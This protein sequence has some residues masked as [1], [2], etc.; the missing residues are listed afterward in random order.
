M[1]GVLMQ[2]LLGPSLEARI[3]V[4][5]VSFSTLA[6]IGD[7]LGT[8]SREDIRAVSI[9]LY[10]GKYITRLLGLR[11]NCGI[12]LLK[13]EF[14]AVDLVEPTLPALKLMLD[15]PPTSADSVDPSYTK[16]VHGLL[17]S[18]LQNVDE[19][20]GRSGAVVALKTK[21]NLLAAVL[22]LTV[23]PATMRISKAALEQCAYLIS[24]KLGES[25]EVRL[26]WTS[27]RYSDH[28]P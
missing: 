9:A 4:L 23:T 22:I 18:C 10:A 26:A 15:N 5:N 27:L 19:C 2:S 12:D 21:N 20:S 6:N 25:P 24:Q 13:N 17:S 8:A 3:Q 1:A 7:V 16:L 11:L 14:S 28:T